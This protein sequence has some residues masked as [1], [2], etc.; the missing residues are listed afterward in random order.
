MDGLWEVQKTINENNN[1]QMKL[2]ISQ[3]GWI[4]DILKEQETELQQIRKRMIQ[5]EKENS[6]L[7]ASR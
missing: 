3:L 6:E 2:I 5:L 1:E 7:K 4:V